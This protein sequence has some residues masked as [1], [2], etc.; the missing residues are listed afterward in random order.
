MSRWLRDRRITVCMNVC[1]IR[2]FYFIIKSSVFICSNLLIFLKP[3]LNYWRFKE[4]RLLN[5]S[6]FNTNPKVSI[7]K[8][9]AQTGST[10]ACVT[11]MVSDRYRCH[12][13]GVWFNNEGASHH[14]VLARVKLWNQCYFQLQIF[15]VSANNSGLWHA[16]KIFFKTPNINTRV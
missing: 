5:M 11:N 9:M 4:P 2:T 16:I 15:S 3:R 7:N 8:W 13:T 14:I 12:P 6:K 1:Y 10:Y